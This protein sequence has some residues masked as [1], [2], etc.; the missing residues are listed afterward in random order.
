MP[1]ARKLPSG[2]WRVQVFAGYE[3]EKRVYRSFTAPTRKQAELLAAQFA[4]DHKE[5]TKA[6]NNLFLS[7]A[8]ERYIENKENVLSP[9]TVREYRRYITTFEQ[10]GISRIR[11]NDLTAEIIQRAINQYAK[12]HSP[13]STRNLHGIISAV[14]AVYLPDF[15]LSTTLPQKIKTE[16]YI[17]SNEEIQLLLKTVKGTEIEKAIMLAAF[18]SLRRSEIAPLKDTDIVGN[19]LSVSKAMVMNSEHEWVIKPP[20]TFSST[21]CVTLPPFVIDILKQND[22]RIVNLHPNQ[23]TDHFE[24]A[25]I[26]AGLPHFRF[27]DLRH[28]QA[29]ILHAMGVP[30]KY[31][32]ERGGWKTDATLKKIYQH[33]MSQKRQEIE[34]KI[35]DYFELQ[36]K[37]SI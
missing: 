4:M 29:S 36:N 20:K 17:P 18:G 28:Y 7:A 2:S 11:M 1:N 25:L 27:H 13:K 22:G 12:D 30:D 35:C 14:M 21:R 32:A 23:I 19:V 26:K 5:L 8:L 34:M 9:S 10:L 6:P 24:T 31:I 33:T 16:T 3:G 37:Q 15:R